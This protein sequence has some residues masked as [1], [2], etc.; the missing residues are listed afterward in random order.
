MT[1]DPNDGSTSNDVLV[2]SVPEQALVVL[3]KDLVCPTCNEAVAELVEHDIALR[4][5]P[6][7]VFQLEG[8]GIGVSVSQGQKEF[9]TLRWETTCCSTVVTIPAVVDVVWD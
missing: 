1:S 9:E 2:F 5:N 4:A 8:G 6:A 7:E 3:D